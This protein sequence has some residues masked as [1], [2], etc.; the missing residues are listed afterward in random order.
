MNNKR[1]TFE[2][3]FRYYKGLPHQAAAIQELEKDIEENGYDIAM[4]RNR[5][6]FA[7][8]SQ[9]G[10]QR[11]YQSAIELTKHFESFHHDAYLCPA[12][13]WTIGWGNTAKT[14]G[15]PVVPGD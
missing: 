2:Q 9:S 3:L 13:V 4:R 12:G 11:D 6:W 14:D 7:T 8:W 5:P 10:K 15:S 1:I